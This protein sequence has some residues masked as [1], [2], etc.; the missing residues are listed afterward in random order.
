MY[1][2]FE[3]HVD[4]D[5]KIQEVMSK[6]V[7]NIRPEEKDWFFTQ[8]QLDFIRQRLAPANT[9]D[10]T[11]IDSSQKRLDDLQTLYVLDYP[12]SLYY[13]NDKRVAGQLPSNY[14]H[15][16]EDISSDLQY[17]CGS[18][19]N[20]ATN[21]NNVELH[22]S[23]LVFEDN[24]AKFDGYTLAYTPQ[25]ESQ[26][27]LFSIDNYTNLSGGFGDNK[28][29]FVLIDLI[30]ND[31]NLLDGYEAHWEYWRGTHYP[32]TFIIIGPD[33]GSFSA[34]SGTG[35]DQEIV[36]TASRSLILSQY[37]DTITEKKLESLNRLTEIN[38]IR[39]TLKFSLTK[40]I[41]SSPVS[42]LNINQLSVHHTP[43]FVVREATIDY[44]RKP[45]PI[46]LSLGLNPELSTN[47]SRKIVEN[48][49][50]KIIALKKG[51]GYEAFVQENVFN[52]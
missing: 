17:K 41:W 52:S 36:T 6:S 23:S 20:V 49:A 28:Q 19:L 9:P 32:N 39:G 51:S 47:V 48:V 25:G 45:M 13:I 38:D 33:Q 21:R 10:K 11:T 4:L 5:L 37:K 16:L 2:V 50:Q 24:V 29:K 42:N 43:D 1:T 40:T 8:G 3:M 31:I 26:D 15:L 22:Y 34:T 44:I 46:S 18:T 14:L 30:L 27:I 12:I 7:G 35:D